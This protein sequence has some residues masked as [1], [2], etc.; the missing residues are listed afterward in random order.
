MFEVLVVGAEQGFDPFFRD[1]DAFQAVISLLHNDL[2]MQLY[3]EM[4]FCP[5]GAPLG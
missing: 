5:N 1:G 2:A 4:A 3:H